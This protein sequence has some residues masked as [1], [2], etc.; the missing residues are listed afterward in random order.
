MFALIETV[1]QNGLIPFRYL[2][3]V[4]EK[5]PSAVTPEN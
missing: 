2:A 5:A 3:A 1:K 4:F